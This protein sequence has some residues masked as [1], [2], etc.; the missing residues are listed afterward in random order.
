MILALALAVAVSGASRAEERPLPMQPG[1]AVRLAVCTG[2]GGSRCWADAPVLRD[3]VDERGNR[4]TARVQ[5][6]QSGSNLLVRARGLSEQQSLEV[7]VLRPAATIASDSQLVRAHNGITVHPLEGA[8]HAAPVLKMH[9]QMW[10]SDTHT[11]HSWD[12]GGGPRLSEPIA[13]WKATDATPAPTLSVHADGD[14]WR[15][16]TDSIEP[17]RVRHRRAILPTGGRGITAPWSVEARPNRPF[18]APPHAGE[19]E[20]VVHAGDARRA[21]IVS[22][23][24]TVQA[25]ISQH[26]VHPPPKALEPVPDDAFELT[27][28][29]AICPTDEDQ[30]PAAEWLTAELRR[31]TITDPAVGCTN[32]RIRF[33]RADG[34]GPEGYGIR[35]RS[36]SIVIESA[37]VAGARFGAMTVADLLGLDGRADAV[38]IEDAPTIARRILFHEVSPQQGPMIR[39][40]Q[41]IDFINRV[42][43]RARFN[44][45]V[46]EMKGG[47]QYESHPR[48][49]RHDAWTAEELDRVLDAAERLG[50]E[51]IP[52]VNSPAHANWITAAYPELMEESTQS[53]LCTRHPGTR[54]LLMDLY[55]ELH[56]R[57]RRPPFI[58]IGHDEIRWRTRWKHE[59]QRCPRCSTTPRWSLLADDLIWAHGALAALG[60]R[61]MMWSDMLV[62][63]WH[64]AWNQMH[65]AANRIPEELRPDFH[66]IS[67][68]RTGDT[69]GSLT[70]LGYAVIRGNT[71][72]ADWKRPGLDALSRGV[73]GE[74]LALFNATPWSSFQGTSG[75]TRDYHHWTNVVLAGATAWNPSIESVPIDTAITALR[76]HP[77]YRPGLRDRIVFDSSI[78]VHQHLDHMHAHRVDLNDRRI[79]RIAV[80]QSVDYDPSG[81]GALAKANRG[82]RKDGGLPVGEVVLEFAD[83]TARTLEP[84]RLGGHTE[85]TE[86][87]GR[88][89]LLFNTIESSMHSGTV[90]HT[91][92]WANPQP[93][94]AVRAVRL[95]ATDPRVS[96]RI[97]AVQTAATA[98][99][100]PTSPA[101]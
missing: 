12:P 67:W 40:E 58:H 27:A 72:Y 15:I 93:E 51:V 19:Y 84:V 2:N 80:E 95:E 23:V 34:F 91:V 16:E 4:Q 61:P 68:G 6:A 8:S 90:S 20:V 96:W 69:V 56:E 45:L 82:H 28:H 11:L 60:A 86:R 76:A 63:G 36:D 25:A 30:R 10:D 74:A 46:L 31:I 3:F 59:S 94:V 39:P 26:G 99:S 47:I 41:T 32:A 5:L 78:P 54:A 44:T 79:A 97:E 42:V 75:P 55:A 66:V 77:A 35:I 1:H 33:V 71:G 100:T 53:L 29:P 98:P 57:F 14:Q 64:G 92:E 52:A 9:V 81:L 89:S 24:P 21:A 62:A 87:S 85:H 17:V 73:A 13:F 43:S 101:P 70:P 88:G 48:L 65:R 49:S 7:V 18:A 37:S 38:D 83:G 22:W 50:I